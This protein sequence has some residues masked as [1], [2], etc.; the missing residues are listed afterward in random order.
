MYCTI[1]YRSGMEARKL[2]RDYPSLFEQSDNDDDYATGN[3]VDVDADQEANNRSIKIVNLDGILTFANATVEFPDIDNPK[4]SCNYKMMGETALLIEP[5]TK[6]PTERVH[7]YGPAWKKYLSKEHH[8]YEA[9]V[10]S[11]MEF[12]RI[13]LMVLGRSCCLLGCNGCTK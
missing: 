4:G 12:A 5:S 11:K 1:G 8:H 3:D 2:Q 7:V 9:A 6:Q 10:F 13:G